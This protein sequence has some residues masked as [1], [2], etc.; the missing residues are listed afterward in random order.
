[1]TAT[2]NELALLRQLKLVKD[3]LTNRISAKLNKPSGDGTDGQLLVADGIGGTRWK[4]QIG[5][6]NIA[7][8]A[9]TTSKLAESSITTIKV[10][11]K[12]ITANKIAEGVITAVPTK[13]SA[14]ENDACSI[15]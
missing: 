14:F 15:T 4:S 2:G 9:V 10:A 12:A 13:V 1:M 5:T 7:D 3:Y 8:G 11:D 6:T